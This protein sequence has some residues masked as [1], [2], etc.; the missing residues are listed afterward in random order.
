MRRAGSRH[1]PRVRLHPVPARPRTHGPSLE[2]C[3]LHPRTPAVRRRMEHLRGRPLGAERD[4][5]GLCRVEARWRFPGCA[6]FG[7]CAASRHLLGGLER[8]NSF[9]RFYLAMVGALDWSLVPA[10]PPEL[11]ILP[12]WFALNI[13]RMSSWTRRSWCR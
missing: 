2:I 1:D 4:G 8:T 9:T 12:S 7:Q 10:V 5:Q 13:Y 6:A 11:A 3:Q